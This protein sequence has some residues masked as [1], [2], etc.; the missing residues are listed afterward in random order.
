MLLQ[1]QDRGV[2][3]N[4]VSEPVERRGNVLWDSNLVECMF[5]KL[6]EGAVGVLAEIVVETGRNDGLVCSGVLRVAVV[7]D[8]SGFAADG[9]THSKRP[10]EHPDVDVTTP[11]NDPEP[12]C[13]V[14]NI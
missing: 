6:R 9:E 8:G 11:F 5:K 12:A 4:Q 13:A 7:G 2:S 1:T 10:N 3:G 14:I